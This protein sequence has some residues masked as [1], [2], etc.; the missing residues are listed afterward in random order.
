MLKDDFT[1]E[2]LLQIALFVKQSVEFGDA[3]V[4]VHEQ[5]ILA[6]QHDETI[7]L[8]NPEL[9]DRIR[10]LKVLHQDSVQKKKETDVQAFDFILR[11]ISLSTR[12]KNEQKENPTVPVG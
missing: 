6:H 12:L 9:R 2:E 7:F 10:D 4:R 3:I 1:P 11:L 5:Q 8:K